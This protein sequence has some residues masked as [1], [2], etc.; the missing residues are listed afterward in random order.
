MVAAVVGGVSIQKASAQCPNID[1]VH[2]SPGI[3]AF[4]HQEGCKFIANAPSKGF[5]HTIEGVYLGGSQF[6]WTVTRTNLS[7]ACTT[8]MFGTI[9]VVNATQFDASIL[10]SDGRYDLPAGFS[11]RRV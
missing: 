5:N 6:S 10:A 3:E 9:S 1:G 4:M 2:K 7:N 11:E 8:V